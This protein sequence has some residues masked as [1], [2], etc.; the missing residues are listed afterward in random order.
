MANRKH[1]TQLVKKRL[2]YNVREAAN[3]TGA[4]P[5]TVRRWRE[6]GL[7]AVEGVYPAIFRGVDIIDFLKRR[8]EARKR[9]TGSGRMFCLRCKDAKW[10]A[11][12]EVEY[13][14]DGPKT[15]A[16]RGL[17]PDCATV[18]SKLTSLAKLRAAAGDLKISMKCVDSRLGETPEPHCNAHS[19]GA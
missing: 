17:C 19:E 15:G 11:F 6:A 9:P 12:G 2:T 14:P 13:W 5:G 7:S 16:L 3:V 18:M 1:T 4:T 10:P 8:A